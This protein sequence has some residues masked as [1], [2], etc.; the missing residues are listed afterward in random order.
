MKPPTGN[1]KPLYALAAFAVLLAGLLLVILAP[2]KKGAG[3]KK[4]A[5]TE[6]EGVDLTYLSFNKDNEKKLEVRCRESQKM[7]DGRLLMK[8]ITATIFKADKLDKDIRISADSGYTR[9]EF[10]DFFL[11]GNALI[12]SPSFT[13]S[14]PSFD[15]KDMNVLSTGDAV[16]FKLRDVTGRAAKGLYYVIRNKYM[17][18]FQTRGVMT[19]AGKAYDF[20][21]QTLRVVEKK[22][23]LLMD[24]D[25]SVAGA[26]SVLR[27]DRIV[28]QFGP[29]FV[30]VESAVADG[31][32]YFQTRETGAAGQRRSREITA[33]HIKLNYDDQGRP[34]KI[35]VAGDGEISLAEDKDVGHIRSGAI[36]ISLNS[37]TQ[38]HRKDPGPGPR[39]PDQHRQGKSRGHRRLV[40]GHLL[41]A[42]RAFRGPGRKKMHL[43]DR[44]FRRP[45][46][47]DPL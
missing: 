36:E 23:Q 4:A 18:M 38:I 29:D 6:I 31:N 33:K 22:D 1:K 13:L 11:Q 8:K 37:E 17:R 19:R 5:D 28:L 32:C 16:A 34:Q 15:L 14:G 46:G 47:E 44:R 7:A 24:R 2:A 35:D 45:G 26:G 40:P 10:N 9:D 12:T 27:A 3:A 42:G 20:Q 21:A 41:Q 39:H 25:A 43:P 30:Q